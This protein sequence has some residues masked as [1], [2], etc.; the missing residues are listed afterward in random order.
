MQACTRKANMPA[1]KHYKWRFALFCL[2]HAHNPLAFREVGAVRISYVELPV[3]HVL[4]GAGIVFIKYGV[5]GYAFVTAVYL[6]RREGIGNPFGVGVIAKL[7]YEQVIGAAM[8]GNGGCGK[9]LIGCNHLVTLLL[10]STRLLFF[11]STFQ[12]GLFFALSVPL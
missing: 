9:G 6:L 8:I 10:L 1:M 11:T 3:E 2:H 7:F 4:E 12:R 5:V